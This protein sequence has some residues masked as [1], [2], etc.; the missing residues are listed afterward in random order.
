MPR[1]SKTIRSRVAAARAEQFGERFGE[2]QRRLPRSAGEGDDRAVGFADGRA[3]AAHRE[4]DR[5]RRG[6]AGVERD[7]QVP[8]GEVVAVAAGGEGDLR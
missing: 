7:G 5:A 2:R 1:W 6:A 8:A 4:R 3:V